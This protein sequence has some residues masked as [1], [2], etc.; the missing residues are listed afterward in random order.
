MLRVKLQDEYYLFSLVAGLLTIY[1]ISL[2]ILFDYKVSFVVFSA[3]IAAGT[4]IYFSFRRP[5]LMLFPISIGS[6]M[7][8]LFYFFE[9]SPLPVTLFQ[10]FLLAGI[11]LLILH[12]FYYRKFEITYS[13]LEIPVFVLLS[14]I[15]ISLVYSP[16]QENGFFNALRF[17]ILLL[18]VLYV[19]NTIQHHRQSLYVLLGLVVVGFVLAAYTMGEYL[20]NPQI[21][22]EN[23]LSAGATL[24]RVS[25]G[26]LYHDPNRFAAILFIPTAVSVAVLFSRLNWKYK[27]MAIFAFIVLLGGII[28]TF[29][30]SGLISVMV[31]ILISITLTRRWKLAM[32]LALMAIL[33]IAVVPELRVAFFT[34]AERIYEVAFGGSD[35]SAGIR[36]MLAIAGMNMFFD[37]WMIGVG[38]GGFPERFTDYYTMQQSVGVNMPHNVTYK[39]MAEIGLL[40][41]LLF[42][43]LFYA[44]CKTGYLAFKQAVNEYDKVLYISLLSSFLAY[45]TFY[46]FY[47]GALTDS[48]LML[49]VGLI[50]AG[51]K[52]YSDSE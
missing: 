38:F 16:G 49:V 7:G 37:S 3:S 42:L 29:S 28:T 6:F 31:I 40:G 45:I 46:Q 4:F 34:T 15:F 26:G 51:N 43:Y 23:M 44:V 18:F 22:I 12:I 48:N 47:G 39:I 30:R 17:V 52:L 32:A 5:W 41:L 2:N 33:M 19:L 11:S 14:L 24:T 20:I 27:V 36:V 9:N 50:F 13:G 25:A 10:F 35:D 8:A 1:L 21:A